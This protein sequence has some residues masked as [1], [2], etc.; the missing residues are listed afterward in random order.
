MPSVSEPRRPRH[1]PAS[2]PASSLGANSN[3]RNLVMM[4]R[5]THAHGRSGCRRQSRAQ[6]APTPTTPDRTAIPAPWSSA[7]AARPA[8]C[9]STRWTSYALAIELGADFIEPDLVAT[10]DGVLDRAPRAEPRRPRPTSST[11]PGVRR[12]QD[13]PRCVDGFADD[14]A[15]SPATSR[16][17][18]S[19]RCA[20][21]RPMP[22][23]LTRLQRP[24]RDPDVRAR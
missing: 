11:A 23:A 7:I 10:K 16:W 12:P 3:R 19:R 4:P 14:R 8:T 9:R 5:G 21:C 6:S 20:P 2:W 24:V 17:P 1:P 15:G 18:R 13:A 22:S